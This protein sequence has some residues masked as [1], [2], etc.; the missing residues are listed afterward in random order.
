M[1]LKHSIITGFRTHHFLTFAK[2]FLSNIC[3]TKNSFLDSVLPRR[4]I[5]RHGFA[6]AVRVELNRLP[7]SIRSQQ[8]SSSFRS[9][10]KTYLF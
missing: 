8:A 10:L 2:R 3:K 1:F 5:G 7:I 4:A 6:A 9:Q